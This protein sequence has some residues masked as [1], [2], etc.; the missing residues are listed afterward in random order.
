M[1]KYSN[2]KMCPMCNG[3]GRISRRK[4]ISNESICEFEICH[5]CMGTGKVDNVTWLKL[6]LL[7]EKVC[8]R[9]TKMHRL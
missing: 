2:A 4:M 7:W 3:S 1:R 8:N 6:R 9:Q 5:Y